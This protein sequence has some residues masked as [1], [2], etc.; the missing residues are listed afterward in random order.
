MRIHP[1]GWQRRVVVARHHRDG[2]IARA[3]GRDFTAHPGG[4]TTWIVKARTDDATTSVVSVIPDG[5]PERKVTTVLPAATRRS[6]SEA[7]RSRPGA[8][9][10]VVVPLGHTPCAV[11]EPVPRRR[12]VPVSPPRPVV[13]NLVREGAYRPRQDDSSAPAD[14]TCCSTTSARSCHDDRLDARVLEWLRLPSRGQLEGPGEST[15]PRLA[16]TPPLR[17]PPYPLR[18]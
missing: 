9:R 8:T 4:M 10:S 2:N 18:T 17:K 12:A 16:E 14:K 15:T 6:G 11:T 13:P 5:E 1:P 3:V 7:A